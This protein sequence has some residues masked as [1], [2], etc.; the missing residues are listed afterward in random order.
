M[1][2]DG[3]CYLD[4]GKYSATWAFDDIN[5]SNTED[6]SRYAI[7]ESYCKFLNSFDE[8]TQFQI[9]INTKPISR[10][11]INLDI[12]ASDNA[13]LE[14]KQ[15]VTE[16][17]ELMRKRYLGDQTYIQ[18]KYIT[19]TVADDSYDAAQKRFELINSE[20]MELLQKMGSGN[21]MLDKIERLTLLR[22]IYRP[23]DDTEIT[24]SS[25]AKTGIID[26]DLI[27]PYSMD[28]SHDDYIKLGDY[29]AQTLFLTDLPQDLSDK[30]IADITKIN[31]KILLTI[32]AAPQN[33]R[34][35]IKEINVRLKSLDREEEDS[36]SRQANMGINSPK[37]PRDL[38][39]AIA[40]TEKFLQDLQTRNEKMFLANI[41]VLVRAKSL[42][43]MDAI[44]NKIEDKVIKSGC[45]IKPF[46]FAQEES[47]DS[48]LPLG[49]NDTF[50][51]R[52][53]TTSSLAVFVPF[54]V[55]EI[56]HPGG[57]CYGRN[58]LSH[59]IIFMDRKRYINAHGFYFGASGSGKSTD[60]KLEVW[61]C[62]FR[63]NDDIIIIDPEGEFTKLVNLL[64]GQVIEVSNSARTRF[65]PFEI[66]EYYGGDDEPDPIPFKSDFIISLVEVR[67]HRSHQGLRQ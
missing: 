1:Y 43:G 36:R 28:T 16:Y 10:S 7:F 55:V 62:F 34:E 40:D 48:V 21:H 26:K 11:H 15:C 5:Y 9:H 24:F 52:T 44:V 64:G 27:A 41:L 37:P 51:K 56:V 2:D 59:N 66:N 23:D 46:T 53:L 54:N 18:Q 32:N 14:Q 29:Y 60:A 57:L 12:K 39:K 33:P 22:E 35:A 61:E 49:R 13:S 45:S 19:V 20:K 6:S 3:I 8:T 50:V 67:A 17:N 38:K 42:E 65:N 47:F 4:N 63:T 31:D 25:M 30:L 58:H